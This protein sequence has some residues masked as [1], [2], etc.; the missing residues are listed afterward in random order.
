MNQES[1]C[2]RTNESA[3]WNGI[4]IEGKAKWKPAETDENEVKVDYRETIMVCG[5]LDKS[6]IQG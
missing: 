6:N 1:I 3:E 5:Q 4:Y 2:E